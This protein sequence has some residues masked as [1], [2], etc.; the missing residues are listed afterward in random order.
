MVAQVCSNVCRCVPQ[1]YCSHPGGEVV[2][3]TMWHEVVVTQPL[4]NPSTSQQTAMQDFIMLQPLCL[5][6][7]IYLVVT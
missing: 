4:G 3:T 2:I 6:R 7:C 5:I 1:K